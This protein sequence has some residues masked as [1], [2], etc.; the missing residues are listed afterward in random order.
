MSVDYYLL[1]AAAWWAAAYEDDP[2]IIT[3]AFRSDPQRFE[4]SY[5]AKGPDGLIH[6]AI[7]YWIRTLRDAAGVPRRVGHIWGV[8]TPGRDLPCL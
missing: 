6:A 8:G 3:S 7:T 2:A 1:H 5:V 4:R